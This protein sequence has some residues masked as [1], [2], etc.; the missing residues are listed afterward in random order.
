VAES[1]VSSH[2]VQFSGENPFLRLKRQPDGPDVA[3]CALWRAYFSPAGRGNVLF[4]RSPIT[5]DRV[6]VLSDNE[7]LFRWVQRIETLLRP[8]FGD[9]G[10]NCE[11][12]VFSTGGDARSAYVEHATSQVNDIRLTWRDF[13]VPFLISL[14][15][16]NDIA[17]DWGVASCM[18]PALSAE[19]SI[20]GRLEAGQAFPE[21]M[22][23]QDC[24]TSALAFA[25]NWYRAS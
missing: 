19:L 14:E 23:G 17:A 5:Q 18:V 20:N 6:L 10:L 24:S 9:T 3:V 15:P 22:A 21:P 8:A 1:V 25:E 7:D 4:V 11:K 12:A 16:G 13:G 2:S